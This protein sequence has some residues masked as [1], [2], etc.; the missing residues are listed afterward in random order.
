MRLA[1]L[2]LLAL[3]LS[4]ACVEIDGSYDVPCYRVM[5][6]RPELYGKVFCSMRTSDADRAA[7]AARAQANADTRRAVKAGVLDATRAQRA[8]DNP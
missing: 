7:S 3:P 6:E 8:H 4:L 5:Q 2:V 1:L